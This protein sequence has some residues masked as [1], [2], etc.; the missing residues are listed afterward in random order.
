MTEFKAFKIRTVNFGEI[1][2]PAEKIIHFKEGIPGFPAIHKFAILEFDHL[3][4]FQYLQSLEDPSIA[5]LVV[6]PFLLKSDYRFDLADADVE[7]LQARG[8]QDISVYA[9]VTIPENPHDATLN[10]MAPILVNQK[11]QCGKQVI[12]LDGNFS[13][14]HPLFGSSERTDAGSV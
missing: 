9:V 10:L 2:V 14:K 12:L 8:L 11:D 4:P 13:T 7:E 6:S 5:L 3:K 1:E